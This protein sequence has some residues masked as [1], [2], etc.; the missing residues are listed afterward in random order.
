M[1]PKTEVSPSRS[2][3]QQIHRMALSLAFYLQFGR[4]KSPPL[5]ASR[6]VP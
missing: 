1:K 6:L 2:L 3:S 5:V 4:P